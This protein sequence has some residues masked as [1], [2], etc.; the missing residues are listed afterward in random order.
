VNLPI[1]CENNPTR[2]VTSMFIVQPVLVL[3]PY[4]QKETKITYVSYKGSNGPI[5][6]RPLRKRVFSSF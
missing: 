3:K 2:I 1:P 6:T 5:E 4:K